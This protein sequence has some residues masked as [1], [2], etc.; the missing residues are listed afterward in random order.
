VRCGTRDVC[1]RLRI[2][3]QSIAA[4][5][6]RLPQFR[7]YPT[8]FTLGLRPLQLSRVLGG[9]VPSHCFCSRNSRRFGLVYLRLVNGAQKPAV[10]NRFGPSGSLIRNSGRRGIGRVLCPAWR[11]PESGPGHMKKGRRSDPF[12][13]LWGGLVQAATVDLRRRRAAPAP[14]AVRSS[15]PAAGTG[16]AAAATSKSNPAFAIESIPGE[17]QPLAGV[18]KAIVIGGKT[19]APTKRSAVSQPSMRE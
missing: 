16:I 1:N 3:N 6:V 13:V 9:R 8:S 17:H 14:R 5:Q 7:H 2:F 4:D 12:P 18:V 15:R 11:D 10:A 19:R